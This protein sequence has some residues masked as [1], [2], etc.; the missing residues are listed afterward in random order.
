VA[1]EEIRAAGEWYEQRGP[2][3]TAD[4]LRAVDAA[5]ASVCRNPD[6]YPAVHKEMHRALLRRFPYSLIYT[7][8]EEELIILACAHWRQR[9]SRWQNRR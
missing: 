8:S 6:Q 3:L 7:F 9:P 4:F 5:V 2:G 1:L